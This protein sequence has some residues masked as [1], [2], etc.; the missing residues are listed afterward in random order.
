MKINVK[1]ICIASGILL[2]LGIPTGWPYDFYILLRWLI[3][4]SSVFV[5]SRF[6][7]SKVSAWAMIFGALAFLFNPILPI[8]LNKSSWVVFDFIGASLYFVAAYSYKEKL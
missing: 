3:F 7:I 4:T 1:W 8:Y 6:Y 5:A 2:I